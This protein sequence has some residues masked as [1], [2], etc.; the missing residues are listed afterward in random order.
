MRRHGL[1]FLAGGA[2]RLIPLLAILAALAGT[3]ACVCTPVEG[4]QECEVER[5]PE[6][7]PVSGWVTIDGARRPG[8]WIVAATG[9]SVRSQVDGA[10]VLELPLSSQLTAR[11]P[12]G[13]S[14]LEPTLSVSVHRDSLHFE[15]YSHARVSGQVRYR[16]QA[17]AGVTIQL[18][19]GRTTETDA[20][21]AYAFEDVP[22]S[23]VLDYELRVDGGPPGIRTGRY[24]LV[25]VRGGDVVHDIEADF[26]N[27]GRIRG[28]VHAGEIGIANV[29]VTATGPFTWSDTT[30]AD[31]RYALPMTALGEYTVTISG[32]DPA[33]WSF[34]GTSQTVTVSD[35]DHVV[36]FDATVVASNEP[37]VATITSPAEGATF[38]VGT[39]ITFTGTAADPEDGVLTGASLVWTRGAGIPLGTG[40][41]VTVSGL[42][43][44]NHRIWLTATDSQGRSAA[45]SILITVLESS[46]PGSI[47]GRVTA[48]GYGIGGVRVSLSGAADAQTVTN[49]NARYTFANLQ[50]G[51]YTV[52]I[53]NY[54]SGVSFSATSVTVTLAGGENRVINFQGS[55]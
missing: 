44:L 46:E 2:A 12:A 42:N 28:R 20:S 16:G 19:G 52:R 13:V 26:L 15:G 22:P 48:N 53:S 45:T 40:T 54:P 37:P 25:R 23:P 11:P 33:A 47:S 7:F 31:G 35:I 17:V 32:F 39:D 5:E 29:I 6:R 36:D 49:G 9:D 24:G 27:G 21:G 51:T 50:P 55:Y 30:G 3:S 43:A 41:S 34:A 18:G 4:E 38:T 10:F 14:F 1:V 8:V